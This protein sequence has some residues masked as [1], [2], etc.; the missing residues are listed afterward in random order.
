MALPHDTISQQ[1]YQQMLQ[2]GFSATQ[3]EQLLT[4]A[5]PARTA[6]PAHTG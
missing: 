3:I 2:H 5:F 1:F 4:G 6:N